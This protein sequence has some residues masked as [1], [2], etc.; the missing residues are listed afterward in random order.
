MKTDEIISTLKSHYNRDLRKEVVRSILQ[1]E[2]E[3]SLPNY[4]IINQI[5]SY[6]L[7]ELNWDIAKSSNNWDETP[8][9]IMCEVFPKIES[10]NWYKEQQFI[11]K[12]E[13]E[14]VRNDK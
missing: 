8:L 3:S 5:F 10:T 13:I 14:V 12:Q 7:Q 9:Q 2:K 11:S 6:V 4:T 1:D